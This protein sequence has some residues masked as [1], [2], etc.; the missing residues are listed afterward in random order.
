[1]SDRLLVILGSMGCFEYLFFFLYLVAT[2][3]MSSAKSFHQMPTAIASCT[4]D[5]AD[6]T[7]AFITI[8]TS[9]TIETSSNKACYEIQTNTQCKNRNR[10]QSGD[11][12]S[13]HQRRLQARAVAHFSAQP[14]RASTSAPILATHASQTTLMKANNGNGGNSKTSAT[15][16][17]KIRQTPRPLNGKYNFSP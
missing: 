12:S 3:L 1:M 11:T 9:S 6:S 15:V 5:S 16:N 13:N 4:T 8:P 17:A 7:S 14:L 10:S 2:S